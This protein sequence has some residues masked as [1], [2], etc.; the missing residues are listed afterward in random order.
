MEMPIL[1]VFLGLYFSIISSNLSTIK[2]GLKA[3]LGIPIIA[4]GYFSIKNPHSST[5]SSRR[6]GSPP[7][8]LIP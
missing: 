8:K 1:I 7:V 6:K 2:I 5:K 4:F 3:L